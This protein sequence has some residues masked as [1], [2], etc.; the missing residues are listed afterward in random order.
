MK[1][2]HAR[3]ACLLA[4][5]LSAGM[6]GSADI[7]EKDFFA[8]LPVVL[9][10]SRLEQPLMDAPVALTVIDRD[11]IQ[12][13]GFRELADLMR[14]VPG[15]YVGQVNGWFHYVTHGFG[16]DYARRMQVLVDGRSI[17]LPT[18][19]G[20]RWDAVPL[21]IEDIERIEVA[22]GPN[23]ATYGANA[24]T[25][26]VNIITRHAADVPDNTLSVKAGRKGLFEVYARHAGGEGD[27][28]YLFTLSHQESDG[29]D[30]QADTLRAPSATLRWDIRPAAGDSLS[31]RA[32]Y[33]GGT[34]RTGEVN[35]A[36]DNMPRDQ[37][38]DSH[39]QQ[40]DWQRELDVFSRLD[41]RLAHSHTRH[42]EVIPPPVNFRVQLAADRWDTELQ[43]KRELDANLRM[44]AGAAL[45]QDNVWS[46]QYYGR[47]DH[48]TTLSQSLFGHFEWRPVS[49]WLLNAGLMLEWHD[50]AGRRASPRFSLHWQP[51][52]FHS[53]RLGASRAYRNPL[54]FEENA[55]F[56]VFF[57]SR[58]PSLKPEEVT[59]TEL[60]YLGQWPDM[61]LSLDLRVFRDRYRNLITSTAGAFKDFNNTDEAT[62]E[63]VDG[64][65]QW[66]P[67][68]DTRIILNFAQT[69]SRSTDTPIYPVTGLPFE[70][71][72]NSTPNSLYGLLVSHR[73]P[74]RVDVSVGYY[75]TAPVQVIGTGAGSI[76]EARRM[77]IRIG[78]DF[79][80]AD[81]RV[82]LA[83]VLQNVLDPYQEYDVRSTY[84]AYNQ[85]DRR[86]YV[87]LKAEF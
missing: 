52:A 59:A 24:F 74:V 41:L 21:D 25:G 6:A 32:G 28:R 72:S 22:R 54:Q 15:Y 65:L 57:V 18:I 36:Q 14:L 45:R 73:F 83:L 1:H 50:I 17:F 77:D 30:L 80:W 58:P 84:A 75:L 61:D 40:L 66:R 55:N 70:Y 20:V 86:G 43:Y 44:V 51:Q 46:P 31:L 68:A 71:F 2:G 42:S 63:G 64:S 38:I 10:A 8:D 23:A 39:Y 79:K 53:L 27:N 13:S 49:D 87:S 82:N 12:A 56:L 29:Y 19:G 35:S 34:R 5:A 67:S 11:M 69:H 33:K 9:T 48:L 47:Q 76:P 81:A 26:I 3:G 16:E 78:R 7:S 4:T 85:F 60:G 37:S 62:L